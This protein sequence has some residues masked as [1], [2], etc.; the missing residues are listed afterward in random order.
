[1]NVGQRIQERR[2]ELKMSVETLAN[3]IG[4]SRATVYRYENGDI[5]KLPLDVL[6]PIAT[7]LHV[8]PAYLMDWE[9]DEDVEDS[10]QQDYYNDEEAAEI[11]YEMA[12][13]PELR[14]LYDVQR[15]MDPD[16]LQAL[17]GMAM[18]LKK[19]SERLDSDDPC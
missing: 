14:T 16:D 2:K 9:D 7:A 6:M 11:A 10:Q 13:R 12:T 1:M 19:K 17:Y 3:K 8:H 4:K 18:V 5:E 15:D